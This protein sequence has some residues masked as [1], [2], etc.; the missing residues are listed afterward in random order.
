MP[1]PRGCTLAINNEIPGFTISL[2]LF[3]LIPAFPLDGGRMLRAILA[4]LMSFRRATQI[5]A[6]VGQLIAIVMGFFG[7]VSGNLV[8]VTR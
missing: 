3:N 1:V 8:L 4:M 5:S 7:I 6:V 2:V